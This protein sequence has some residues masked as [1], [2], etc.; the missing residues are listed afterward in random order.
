MRYLFVNKKD[1]WMI[2]DDWGKSGTAYTGC[3]SIFYGLLVAYGCRVP[4]ELVH[5]AIR[6]SIGY[7]I[8]IHAAPG[9]FEVMGQRGYRVYPSYDTLEELY[10]AHLKDMI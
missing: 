10:A 6:K 5:A 1:E 4:D 3:Q 7:R 8:Q 2:L 9:E